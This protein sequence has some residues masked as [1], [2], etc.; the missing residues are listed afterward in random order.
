MTTPNQLP[1][2]P[3]ASRVRNPEM[4]DPETGESVPVADLRAEF[5]RLSRQAPRDPEA[6]RAF[7]ESKLEMIRNDPALSLAQKERAVEQL[8]PNS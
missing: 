2:P 7:I 3:G 8:R 6:E 4:T 5:E 1:L